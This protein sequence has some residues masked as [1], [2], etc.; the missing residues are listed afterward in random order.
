MKAAEQCGHTWG[1][2]RAVG[3][4]EMTVDGHGCWMSALFLS[5]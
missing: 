4:A 1:L 2:S 5:D 3:L